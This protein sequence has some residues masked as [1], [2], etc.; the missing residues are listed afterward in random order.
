MVKIDR[1]AFVNEALGRK[2]HHG[3][4]ESMSRQK[5]NIS[6]SSRY[7]NRGFMTDMTAD[8]MVCR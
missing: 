5:L 8:K 4:W 3:G 1:H 7:S 6:R 2:Q